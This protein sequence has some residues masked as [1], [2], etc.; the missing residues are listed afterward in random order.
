VHPT[1]ARTRSRALVRS[2]GTNAATCDAADT[3][4]L[5]GEVGAWRATL[6]D[7]PHQ[8]G[9]LVDDDSDSDHLRSL[10]RLPL[11]SG[12]LTE[13]VDG[14][15][16]APLPGGLREYDRATTVMMFN[17][18][19]WVFISSDYAATF[20]WTAVTRERTDWEMLWLVRGDARP[21]VDFDAD[22]VARIHLLTS[23]EDKAMI[24]RARRCA[25][26][27]LSPRALVPAGGERGAVQ[28]LVPAP[29]VGRRRRRAA[30]MRAWVA[31]SYVARG[32]GGEILVNIGPLFV[33]ATAD[34]CTVGTAIAGSVLTVQL[35]AL[36]L[37]ARLVERAALRFGVRRAAVCAALAMVAGDALGFAANGAVAIL[38]P[39]IAAVIGLR[40]GFWWPYAVSIVA[41]LAG[42]LL[43]ASGA[44]VFSFIA[45]S[46]A[47]SGGFM[48][49]V[50][51]LKRAMARADASARALNCSMSAMAIGCA[52]GPAFLG[53]VAEWAG[54]Y[55]AAAWTFTLLT[56]VATLMLRQPV[57][58]AG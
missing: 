52:A 35:G 26:E 25:V 5:A 48:F 27:A 37:A 28:R 20:R 3:A 53:W 57:T 23:L 6:R 40:W 1:F 8:A 16:V 46:M 11:A 4:A 14:Q 42:V 47:F 33:G 29:I 9:V 39:L 30:L 12:Y 43:L 55:T 51:Y 17:P 44:G 21:G 38:C 41:Q 24:E 22:R 31:I 10:S 19:S 58:T 49:T 18:W 7:L 50:L 2:I 32:C 54:G 36:A 56:L 13:S 45:G 34:L 15:P